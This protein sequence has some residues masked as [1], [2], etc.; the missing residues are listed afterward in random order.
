MVLKINIIKIIIFISII[1][2]PIISYADDHL[3]SNRKD[4][5]TIS[6]AIGFMQNGPKGLLD[7][8]ILYDP[9]SNESL[10]QA[11]HIEAI[12]AEPI[13][14][15]KVRL[16]GKKLAVRYLENNKKHKVIFVT[17][18][19]VRKYKR[20]LEKAQNNGI[21]TVSTDEYCLTSGGCLL[22]VKTT[23]SV[24]ISMNTK[25]AKRTGVRFASAFRMMIVRK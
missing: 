18:G 16:L 13:G 20:L 24:E 2:L 14:K 8:A 23:P 19:V 11:K 17:K 5:A 6:K 22:S 10:E 1:L 9:N 3:E 21:I 12:V 15:G 25:V 7:M 4:I